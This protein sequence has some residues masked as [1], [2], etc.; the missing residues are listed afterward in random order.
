[1]KATKKQLKKQIIGILI[2]LVSISG[3]L[4]MTNFHVHD[5]FP[6]PKPYSFTNTDIAYWNGK[7]YFKDNGFFHYF[8]YASIDGLKM[9]HRLG[10]GKVLRLAGYNN[11][12]YILREDNKLCIY[13]TEKEKR[14]KTIRLASDLEPKQ[15]QSF[16]LL[17]ADKKGVLL[18][19]REGEN[20]VI[21]DISPEGKIKVSEINSD[22]ERCA[23]LQRYKEGY[24]YRTNSDKRDN[25]GIYTWNKDTRTEIKISNFS[26]EL[27]LYT[28]NFI[29]NDELIIGEAESDEIYRIKLDGSGEQAIRFP[30]VN[31]SCLYKDELYCLD[32]GR[33]YIYN[34]KTGVKKF[35][36]I[37]DK[38]GLD[39][40]IQVFD[41]MLFVAYEDYSSVFNKTRV[42]FEE[43]K[44]LQ[45]EPYDTKY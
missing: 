33:L 2:L 40:N 25:D 26:P 41:D 32:G 16:N 34:L 21:A 30:S 3:L 9:T 12:V 15:L 35:S 24:I 10:P 23:L 5:G 14:L 43:L 17:S 31:A 6:N 44:N 29:W 36:I 22:S 4:W 27:S 39:G 18:D 28:P 11:R 38:E 7:I 37:A 13:D 45:W 8:S 19:T 1:M 42:Y 20:L